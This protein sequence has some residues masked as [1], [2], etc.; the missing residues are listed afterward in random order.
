MSQREIAA[1]R[2]VS[3]GIVKPAPPT[4]NKATRLQLAQKKLY[5]S[6]QYRAKY[7]RG[8]Q[9][10]GQPGPLL[11]SGVND[12]YRAMNAAHL[13]SVPGRFSVPSTEA[14]GDYMHMIRTV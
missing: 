6:F 4:L 13:P 9:R 2:K 3:L 8:P 14:A 5:Q 12:A 1:E 11:H 7:R 10:I